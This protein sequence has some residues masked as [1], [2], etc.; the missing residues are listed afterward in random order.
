MLDALIWV[1]VVGVLVFMMWRVRRRRPHVGSGGAGAVYDWLN[2]DKRKAIE[3]VTE[4]R[5]ERQDPEHADDTLA[6]DAGGASRGTR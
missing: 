3:V 5:A 6:D 4:G 1:V 2:D